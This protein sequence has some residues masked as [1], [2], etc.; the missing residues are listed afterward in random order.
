M[1]RLLSLV[2]VFA[3][4][5]LLQAQTWQEPQVPGVDLTSLKSTQTIYFYNVDADVFAINGMDWNTNSTTTR[6]TNG[7]NAVSDP[8]KCYA[9]VNGG[10]VSVR[11]QSYPEKYIS[12]LSANAYD[13]YVDQASGHL[14]KFTKR[15][16]VAMSIS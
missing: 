9:F 10:N 2:F 5:L 16:K 4:S 13:I 11:L 6:L 15:Q 14:F 3:M 8:Q 7:D 1:K 12:C